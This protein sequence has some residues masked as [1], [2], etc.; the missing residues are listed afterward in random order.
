MRME[1]PPSEAASVTETTCAHFPTSAIIQLLQSTWDFD[2]DSRSQ[3]PLE[4]EIDL[5]CEQ[6]RAVLATFQFLECASPG[7]HMLQVDLTGVQRPIT[8]RNF[9]VS[10]PSP[11]E[12][13]RVRDREPGYLQLRRAHLLAA[14]NRLHA[15]TMRV[16][17][18]GSN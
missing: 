7:P 5:D 11:F 18:P 16:S 17:Q 12:R 9:H 14:L 3:T 4:L 6:L 1:D 8:A 13:Y 2:L 15:T 10:L